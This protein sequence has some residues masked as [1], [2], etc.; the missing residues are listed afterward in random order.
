MRRQTLRWGVWLLSL[1]LAFFVL[2]PAVKAQ[3]PTPTPT[4][5]IP[6]TEAE[7]LRIYAKYPEILIGADE[8]ANF[9]LTL[10]VTQPQLVHLEVADLPEGWEYEFRGGV[11]TVRAVYALPEEDVSLR[12]QVTPA[13]DAKAGDYTFYAVAQGEFGEARFPLTI[14]LKEKTPPKLTLKVDLP[15]LKGGPDTTFRFGLTIK[16]ESDQD[17]T[18][19]LQADTPGFFLTR[20]LSFGKEITSVPIEANSS[21]RIDLEVKPIVDVE[22]GEYPIRIRV[23]GNELAAEGQVMVIITGMPKLN[24]STPTGRLSG[25]ARAG[26]ETTITFVVKNTGSAPAHNVKISATA[27]SRWEVRFD[28]EVI[29][30]LPVGEEVE[31]KMLLKPDAKAV[32]GDYMVTVRATS[33]EGPRDTLDYRVTVTTSTM[34]GLVGLGIIAVAV[35]VIAGAVSYYGRR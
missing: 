32:A 27:P 18:V 34:W 22:A 25:E 23:Q 8:K 11:R 29:Q 17:I 21:K 31:F 10:E 15:T 16:N 30:Q 19:S 7:T 35:L 6:T 24:L 9:E 5:E 1:V 3:E 28:P 2:V 14:T 13:K 26:E 4:T 20:F 12:L 33:E